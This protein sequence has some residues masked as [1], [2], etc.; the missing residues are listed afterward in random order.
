MEHVEGTS[1][2]HRQGP[3]L[4]LD[5]AL[6][7]AQEICAAL[8]AA[9]AANV[10]HYDIKPSNIMLTANGSI[11]VVDFGIAGFTHTH[12][13]T[14]APTTALSRSEPPSTEHRNSSW[15]SAATSVP[16]ST[17][18]AASSS[19]CSPGSPRSPTA[20]PCPSSAANLTKSPG[21]WPNCAPTSPHRLLSC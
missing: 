15:T 10:V 11:K 9:H 4:N 18:W 20:P 8:V 5:R 16:T 21:M 7:I 13:F 2:A 17:P 14:V 1:L 3:P 19:P 12:T 6:E